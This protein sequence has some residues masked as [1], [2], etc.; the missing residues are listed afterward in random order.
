MRWE[1][2]CS[3]LW[4]WH[5]SVR[6]GTPASVHLCTGY[7][8]PLL[9]A[10]ILHCVPRAPSQRLKHFTSKWE[11][12]GW[13]AHDIQGMTMPCPASTCCQSLTHKD[14][15]AAP[16]LL[17]GGNTHSG[18]WSDRQEGNIHTGKGSTLSGFHTNGG[19][20]W[21]C[22]W[23]RKDTTWHRETPKTRVATDIRCPVR[24]LWH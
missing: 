11:I 15:Q 16:T 5:Q 19:G 2:Y 1:F 8:R 23:Q 7:R 22:E 13:F 10:T 12:K 4:A 9:T 6:R 20:W 17:C 14:M 21:Q 3:S 24:L 18:R